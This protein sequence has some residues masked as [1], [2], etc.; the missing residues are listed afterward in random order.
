MN[1]QGIVITGTSGAGKTAISRRL[2]EIYS[3]FS[4]CKLL[5]TRPRRDEDGEDYHFISTDEFLQKRSDHQLLTDIEYRGESYGIS[6]ETIQ[7][8]IQT[9]KK[10]PILT[11]SP[12]A[13]KE[14]NENCKNQKI[15]YLSFFIDTDN[16]TLEDRV[17][18]R[19]GTLPTDFAV[20]RE[21]DREF[22]DS[23][24]YLLK[25]ED[26]IDDIVQLIFE[27]WQYR[28]SGGLLSKK[29]ITLFVKCGSLLSNIKMTNIEGASYDLLLGDQFVQNGSIDSLKNE[30]PF[31]VLNPGDYAIVSSKEI[32]NLPKDIAGRYDITV[33][34]F[35]QGL[36]LS[37][38]PQVDPGF[39][40]SLLCLLFNSSNQSI[41]LKRGEHYATIEFVKLIEPTNAYSGPHQNQEEIGLYMPRYPGKGEIVVMREEINELK[42]YNLTY[43]KAP[44]VISVIALIATIVVAIIQFWPKASG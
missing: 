15:D 34:L 38:G 35:A 31:I 6:K 9:N 33:G 26:N 40:G 19:D 2:C 12:K 3:E 25:N 5:T 18:Q 24:I 14:L 17:K 10:I 16:Q 37:N 1:Y 43:S 41:S 22:S 20:Q 36:I 32:A 30:K 28:Y 21:S 23:A 4:K 39:K 13:L 29:I 11:I 27:M 8:I 44:V 7:E 42:D